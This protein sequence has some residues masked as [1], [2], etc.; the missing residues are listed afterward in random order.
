MRKKI[1]FLFSLILLFSPVLLTLSASAA[2]SEWV[3]KAD[4]LEPRTGG[5]T[6]SINGKI[7]Y[8]GG[9][10]GSDHAASGIKQNS[11]YEYDPTT[12]TWTVKADMPTAR[13]GLT[14]VV[15]N[16]KIYAIGGYYNVGTS[17]LRTNKVEVYDPSTDSWT[18][19]LTC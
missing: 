16:N 17:V 12:D 7:Y 3:T 15:Y 13:A 4:L 5:A 6:A 9:A 11:T 18:T 14:A 8:F 19:A 2:S 1:V 10:S